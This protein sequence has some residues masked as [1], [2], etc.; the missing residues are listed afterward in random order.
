MAGMI[1]P[2]AQ[3]VTRQCW[4]AIWPGTET[5]QRHT[6]RPVNRD[7][8]FTPYMFYSIKPTPFCTSWCNIFKVFID[9]CCCDFLTHRQ[10]K[11]LQ[12]SYHNSSVLMVTFQQMVVLQ[13][14]SGVWQC[15]PLFHYPALLDTQKWFISIIY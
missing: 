8:Q 4:Q 14:W 11:Y 13:K 1:S 15:W 12:V 7:R 5:Q 10:R 6:H 9:M 2:S 3:F